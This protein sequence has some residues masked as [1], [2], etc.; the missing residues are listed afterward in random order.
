LLKALKR[1]G[2]NAFSAKDLGKLGLTDDQQLEVAFENQAVIFT[3]DADFLR[4]A[5]SKPHLGIIYVHQQK[6]SIGECIKRLKIIAET[7]SAQEIQTKSSSC[8]AIK[9][10]PVLIN[11]KI[12]KI[13]FRVLIS[14]QSARV[15]LDP[16]SSSLQKPIGGRLKALRGRVLLE[17]FQAISKLKLSTYGLYASTSSRIIPK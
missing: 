11:G 4:M 14:C 9:N 6:L 8:R 12:Q 13:F 3:Y 1:R 5:M 15:Y 2:V 16:N 7:K 10:Q 17:F